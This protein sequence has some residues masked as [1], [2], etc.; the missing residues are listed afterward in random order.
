MLCELK[1]FKAEAKVY[2]EILNN[3]PAYGN[4]MDIDVEKYL[5]RAK[6]EAAK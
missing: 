3:Y 1:D 6:A 2:E 5:E 4:Q